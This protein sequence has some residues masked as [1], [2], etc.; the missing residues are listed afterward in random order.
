MLVKFFCQMLTAAHP[1]VA[2]MEPPRGLHPQVQIPPRGQTSADND[3]QSLV[4][5]FDNLG[6]L[7]F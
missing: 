3:L 7:E 6:Y 4:N 1:L 5:T 2:Q